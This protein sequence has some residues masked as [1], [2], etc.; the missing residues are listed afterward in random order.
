MR[1]WRGFVRLSGRGLLTAACLAGTTGCGLTGSW[2]T[3]E[4]RPQGAPFPINEVTFDT[5]GKYT[6]T[7]MFDARGAYQQDPHTTTGT[8]SQA[9]RTLTFSP[10]GGPALAYKAQRRW[11]GKLVMRL[12]LPGQDR[13]VSAVLA[14]APP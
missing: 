8:Y 4:V 9:W 1:P 14:P 12:Q 11:D 3:V 2:R 6:A 7:G 10:V 5:Q 13:E